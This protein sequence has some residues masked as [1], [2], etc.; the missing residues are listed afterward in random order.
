[1]NTELRALQAVNHVP[2]MIAHWSNDQIC[3]FAND[4]Y[5]EWFGRS[6]QAMLGITMSELLGDHYLPTL[7]YILGVLMGQKQVFERTYPLSGRVLKHGV[8]T[9]TPEFADQGVHGFW[10]H[11][12]DVT[13]L[14]DREAALERARKEKDAALDQVWTLSS[15]LPMCS[16]CKG[17]RNS[18]GEWHALEEYVLQ[19][20]GF[21][22]S[23]SM[24][25]K[26]VAVHYPGL[27]LAG[28]GHGAAR[29]ETAG[30]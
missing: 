5:R 2:A 24:C 17:I 10:A 1:M 3:T 27:E 30:T 14:R 11:V 25:P 6:P 16:A 4:A 12:A 29:M 8:V 15:L 19:R 21:G 18:K 13:I 9:Y 28:S 7:P 20:D 26:C 23:H 22:V